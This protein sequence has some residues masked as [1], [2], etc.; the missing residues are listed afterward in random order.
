MTEPTPLPSTGPPR[1]PPWLTPGNK[2]AI[3]LLAGLGAL[4]LI[5]VLAQQSTTRDENNVGAP[6][7]V[8]YQ[9]EGTAAVADLTY[10]NSGGDTEQQSGVSA[11]VPDVS[12]TLPRGG[13]AYV[14]AQNMTG[15]GDITCRILVD[16][17][18]VKE[19]TST[20]G[21]AIATCSASVP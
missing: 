20:G 2:V 18:V 5:G 6:A 4:T 8:V 15:T 13:L 11:P 12:V 7:S 19:T 16:G 21:Y 3:Y 9:I 10:T 17:A 1:L 14:A